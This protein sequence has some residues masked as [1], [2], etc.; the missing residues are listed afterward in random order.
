[1]SHDSVIAGMGQEACFENSQNVLTILLGL[2]YKN[3]GSFLDAMIF[4]R[5]PVRGSGALDRKFLFL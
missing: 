3:T 2:C 1:M 4:L 5:V